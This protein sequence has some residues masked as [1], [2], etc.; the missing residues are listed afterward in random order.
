MPACSPCPASRA[1]GSRRRRTAGFNAFA[2]RYR[3]KFN[4]DPTRISTLSYDAVSLAAALAHA[5]G[6]QRY[7]DSVLLNKSG[8]NGADGVFRFRSDGLNDRGLSVLQINDGKATTGQPGAAH[9]PGQ[10]GH[11]TGI[12]PRARRHGSAMR[13][14]RG[15]PRRLRCAIIRLRG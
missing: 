14:S 13:R 6:S 11:V 1:H 3:A 4:T 10:L 12:G 5:Q 9:L 8:F 2:N 15:W 7:A